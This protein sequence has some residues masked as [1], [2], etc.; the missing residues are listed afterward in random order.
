MEEDVMKLNQ[1]Y[2]VRQEILLHTKPERKAVIEKRGILINETQKMLVFDWFKV[3]K[4]TVI[5]IWIEQ[6]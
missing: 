1:R 2:V 5:G 4:S 3:R 6:N